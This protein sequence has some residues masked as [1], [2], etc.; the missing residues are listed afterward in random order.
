MEVQLKVSMKL[1][2]RNNSSS[3]S[4]QNDLIDFFTHKS[5]ETYK[6][7]LSK[8]KTYIGVQQESLRRQ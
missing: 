4:I 1:N 6:N 3:H 8:P 2:T 7:I 5:K